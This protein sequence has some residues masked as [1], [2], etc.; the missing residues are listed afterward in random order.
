MESVV[1]VEEG[2]EQRV[3]E[4]AGAAGDE[5]VGVGERGEG[6]ARVGEDVGEVFGGEWLVC[7][8]Y[9]YGSCGSFGMGGGGRAS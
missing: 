8:G 2:F 4:E 7:H 3:A 9:Q 5:E 1:G 6:F